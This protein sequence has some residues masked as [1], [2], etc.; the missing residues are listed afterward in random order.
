MVLISFG[1][2]PGTCSLCWLSARVSTFCTFP[3]GATGLRS[4]I[5]SLPGDLFIV[6]FFD[7]ALACLRLIKECSTELLLKVGVL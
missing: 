5:V 4:L 3:L 7:M 6:F 1:E 2:E